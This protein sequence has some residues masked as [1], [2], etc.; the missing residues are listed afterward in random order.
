MN[1]MFLV[2]IFVSLALIIFLALRGYS[3]LIIGPLCAL[4]VILT[5][6]MDIFAALI[7]NPNSYMAG[8]GLFIKSYFPIFLL[9]AILAKYMDESGAARSIANGTLKL[10]GTDNPYKVMVAVLIVSSLLTYGG[11]SLYVA[12]FAIVP[13]SRPLFRELDIPWHLIMIPLVGGMAT[14][15]MTML[16]GTPSIQNAIPTTALGTTLMAAPL[17]GIIGSVVVIAFSLWY[18]KI[19]LIKAKKADEHYIVSASDTQ[20]VKTDNL[21]SVGVSLLPLL[22][23]IVII[24]VGSVMKIPNILLI[25]L[26]ISIVSAAVVF[27]KHI[28]NHTVTLNTG[29]TAAVVPAVFTAAAVGFGIVVAAAPGFQII[30][31]LILGIPGSPLLSLSVSTGLMSAVTGSSSGSLGI[32]MEAFSKTY[33]A[34]GINP[35]I[36]HRIAAMSSGPLSAMP[37]SGAVLALLALTGLTH[38]QAYRHIFVIVV[39]GGLIS[40]AVALVMAIVL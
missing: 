1:W 25:A 18:M 11:V 35:E 27:N 40:L 6:Q 12:M 13:L 24:I 4:V 10:T 30:S 36:I 31:N 15:T 39:V 21:P 9:G 14:F 33:L 5:N 7:T 17:I 29:A 8:V 3:I 16:P 26:L 37:H 34:Q 38:K 32:I 23:L 28:S 22:L 20:D 19:E 2:G